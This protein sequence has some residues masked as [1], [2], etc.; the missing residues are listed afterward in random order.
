MAIRFLYRK[1]AKKKWIEGQ[2][3]RNDILRCIVAL[4]DNIENGLGTIILSDIDYK[5]GIAQVHIKMAKGHGRGKGYG[6]DALQT[7]VRYAFDE[8][9]LNC[10]YAYVLA[11]NIPSQKLFEKCRFKREGVLRSRVFKNGK[12]VDVFS[13]SILREDI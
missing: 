13:F 5:N 8:L 2:E 11:Y 9:R 10:I 3:N 6:T 4:K 12:Y 7:F 1:K